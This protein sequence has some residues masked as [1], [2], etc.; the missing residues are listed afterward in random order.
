MDAVT[1]GRLAQLPDV[2]YVR[3]DALV[4]TAALLTEYNEHAARLWMWR[5]GD[6]RDQAYARL[7]SNLSH[8]EWN[9]L[10]SQT[11][12]ST[13]LSQLACSELN[14]PRGRVHVKGSSLDERLACS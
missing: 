4:P 5:S 9:S 1:G 8:H 11:A 12:L 10:V 7:R 13:S 6:L 2:G 14:H 3:S